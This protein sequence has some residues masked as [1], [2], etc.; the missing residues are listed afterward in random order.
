VH[1]VVH[2]VCILEILRSLNMWTIHW[3]SDFNGLEQTTELCEEVLKSDKEARTF[4]VKKVL[5]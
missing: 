5:S 4:S 1:I 2:V 3:F